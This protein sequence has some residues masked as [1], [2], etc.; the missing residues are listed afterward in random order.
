MAFLARECKSFD[1]TAD[2]LMISGMS[3]TQKAIALGISGWFLF[4]LGDLFRKIVFADLPILVAQ[5]YISLFA[6]VFALFFASYTGGLKSLANFERPLYVLQRSLVMI[7]VTGGAMVGLAYLELSKFYI[8]IFTTPIITSFLANFI[9]KER[10]KPHH[11]IILLT[12]FAGV[13]IM[14][15]PGLNFTDMNDFSLGVAGALVNAVS[16]ALLSVNSKFFKEDAPKLPLIIYPFL[17]SSGTFFLCSTSDFVLPDLRQ[18]LFLVIP[19]M[20][21]ALA[22]IFHIK[23][24]QIVAANTVAPF[25]YTQLIWGTL[26]GY[27]FFNE[28]PDVSTWIGGAVIIGA[29][30]LLYKFE[31]R[32]K[33]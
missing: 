9:F 12:G 14:V 27:L 10:I 2:I 8:I 28:F 33:K 3:N 29:G 7:F 11:V 30:L 21:L 6:A 20:C 25:H 23:A 22:I 5:G 16:F 4:S 24:F 19:G 1:F 26:F 15:R 31:N 13:L 18:A 17:A 32:R